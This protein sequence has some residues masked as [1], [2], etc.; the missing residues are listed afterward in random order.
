MPCSDKHATCPERS[1]WIPILDELQMIEDQKPD[2]I[3][4]H[5]RKIS[6]NLR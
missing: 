1:E 6:V 2:K 4:A 3:R 5:P